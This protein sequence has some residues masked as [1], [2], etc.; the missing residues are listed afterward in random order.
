MIG[1][2][3]H[4]RADHEQQLQR[5]SQRSSPVG[6]QAAGGEGLQPATHHLQGRKTNF[7]E[8]ISAKPDF[9]FHI[10]STLCCSF[11]HF[12]ST[13]VCHSLLNYIRVKNC[14]VTQHVMIFCLFV[15]LYHPFLPPCHKHYPLSP[16]LMG[17]QFQS[18]LPLLFLFFVF[19]CF[20]VMQSVKHTHRHTAM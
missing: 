7:M 17:S 8:T 11:F 14:K 4:S 6:L 18:Y 1:R 19:F 20:F 5:H 10:L 13:K 3:R 2:I 15:P 9:L 12:L 16:N